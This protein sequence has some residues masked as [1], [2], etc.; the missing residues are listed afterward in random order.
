MSFTRARSGL[1][2]DFSDRL[3]GAGREEWRLRGL[4]DLYYLICKVAGTRQL[5]PRLSNAL[6]GA[7]RT[8]PGFMEWLKQRIIKEVLFTKKVVKSDHKMT[9]ISH[10]HSSSL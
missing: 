9:Q 10:C 6:L 5:M 1:L 2:E 8:D 3:Y 4:L 7:W